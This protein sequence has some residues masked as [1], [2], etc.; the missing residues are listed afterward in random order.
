MLF[1][2]SF[3]K[4]CTVVSY[5]ISYFAVIIIYYPIFLITK[6]RALLNKFVHIWAK[7]EDMTFIRGFTYMRFK[8]F[9]RTFFLTS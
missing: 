5:L 2:I 4:Q 6:K 8:V 7:Q 9:V 3:E 1:Q